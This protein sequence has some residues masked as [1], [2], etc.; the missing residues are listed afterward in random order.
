MVEVSDVVLC[1]AK[2]IGFMDDELGFVVQPVYGEFVII[3]GKR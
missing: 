2:S 1:G 3:A